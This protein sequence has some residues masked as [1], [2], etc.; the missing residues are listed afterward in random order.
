MGCISAGGVAAAQPNMLR[1]GD[2]E[3]A[4]PSTWEKRTPDG[5]ERVLAILSD[6]AH[7]GGRFARIVNRKP[8]IS[9]WR[10]GA[11]KALKLQ[12]G[13]VVRLSGWI[14]T[15]LG[16]DGYAALRLYCMGEREEILS[17][18]QA[19]PVKGKSDWKRYS[20]TARVPG[21]TRHAM[22]Y[23][24]LQNAV[25]TA[26]FDDLSLSLVAAAKPA[27]R[28]DDILLLTDLENDHAP[29]RNFITLYP[30]RCVARKPSDAASFE[31]YRSIVVVVRDP[32]AVPDFHRIQKFVG[33]GGSVIAD[34][35]TYARWRSVEAREVRSMEETRL[36]IKEPHGATR[37]FE[38][39]DVIPWGYRKEGQWAQTVL[40]GKMPGRI[41]GESLSGE[42][43]LATE[44]IGKGSLL[45]TDLLSMPEPIYN[46]PGSFNKYLFAANL[47]GASVRH[48]RHFERRLS[49]AEFVDQMRRVAG[50]TPGVRIED[51][52]PGHGDT[53][54]FSLNIGDPQKPAFLIYA[55]TH[56]SE[57]EPAYGL[58]TLARLLGANG[59]E[60]I[61]DKDRYRVKLIPILN[62]TGYDANTRKNASD[63]DLNRNGGEWWDAFKGRDS[64]KDG[65]AGPG[66]ND[67]KG[68]AP[69]SENETRT[70]RDICARTPLWAAL[71]FHGN[72]GGRGNNRLVILPLTGRDDNEERVDAAVRAFNETIRDRFIF[73]E[74]NRP[75]VQQYEIE[76]MQFDSER[77]TL[78]HTV[79]KNGYGFLCEV[80][81][82]Y[83]GTYGLVVQTE[84]VIETCL[85]FF[86][87]YRR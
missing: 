11:D 81:A 20:L 52:G 39:G 6:G 41:V 56:G 34:L 64:D 13:S 32:G 63:V 68:I 53:R 84:I 22:V 45:A 2:F 59:G 72:A 80:P 49:Y 76:A 47:I 36:R 73:Q 86:G 87:A 29:V 27:V 70:L 4:P 21:G 78:F 31:N 57:W 65:V 16:V 7:S 37:G 28:R 25:G 40:I 61:Y 5:P 79:C 58:L 12:P 82:G 62:P 18:T 35:R 54:I 23:L 75:G 26:D 9:R 14:R 85:A 51:E 8:A 43:L 17:Q 67:W 83:R 10:Q 77:P 30:E 74:A 66:D 24:E 15:D 19:R 48:G 33:S 42:A 3:A 38:A 60:A 71:D 46:Q 50:E 44:D 55:A 69:F 1:D